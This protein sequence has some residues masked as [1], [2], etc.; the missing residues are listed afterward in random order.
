MPRKR[1]TKMVRA[2]N[3]KKL[4]PSTA[5][6]V[7][8]IVDRKIHRAA[9][10]KYFDLNQIIAA[11]TVATDNTGSV[12]LLSGVVESTPGAFNTRTGE[13]INPISLEFRYDFLSSGTTTY[14]YMFR[15]I[16]FQDRQIR[17]STLPLVADVLEAVLYNSPLSHIGINAGRF[18]ILYDHLWDCPIPIDGVNVSPSVH[19][20]IKLKGKIC[21]T[22][23]TTG[24]QKNNIYVLY[25]SNG[26]SS[27]GIP[28]NSSNMNFYSRLKFE[29]E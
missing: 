14:P 6:A 3:K 19:K 17:T 1:Q 18:K 9:E 26:N 4:A 28:V 15:I 12:V 5:K 8:K 20:T 11:S 27:T 13:V 16:I 23:A 10:N 22:N 29:D 21:Y 24:T 25:L 7:G 2:M